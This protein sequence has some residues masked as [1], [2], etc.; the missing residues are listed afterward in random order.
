MQSIPQVRFEDL[1][2]LSED[3][4]DRIKRCGCVVVRD[5]VDDDK[6]IEWRESLR[7]F[8]KVN[9]GVEGELFFLIYTLICLSEVSDWVFV[10][11]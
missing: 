8:V 6:A 5:V 4:L 9:Q 7:E 10:H 1:D 11:R 3:V 2:R